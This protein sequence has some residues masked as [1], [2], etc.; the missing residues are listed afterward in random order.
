MIPL[1]CEKLP[2]F[3]GLLDISDE[4]RSFFNELFSVEREILEGCSVDWVQM[5]KPIIEGLFNS[6]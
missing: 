1:K 4:I 5:R 3:V 2:F 6:T